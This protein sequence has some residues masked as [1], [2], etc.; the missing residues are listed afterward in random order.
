MKE[1][2]TRVDNATGHW[3][4][5]AR[6]GIIHP[7]APIDT[8]GHARGTLQWGKYTPGAA[9]LHGHKDRTLRTKPPTRG[10]QATRGIGA[11]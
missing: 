2:L 5:D 4:G 8:H 1:T 3:N 9:Q 11:S 7:G 6:P 10:L